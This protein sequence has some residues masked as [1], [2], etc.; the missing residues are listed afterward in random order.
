MSHFIS[1]MANFSSQMSGQV[2]ISFQLVTA[3]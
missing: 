1:G 3:A 2:A